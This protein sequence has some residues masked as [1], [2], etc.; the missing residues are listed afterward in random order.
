MCSFRNQQRLLWHLVRMPR[1]Y[2]PQ[3]MQQAQHTK[4][5]L[6]VRARTRWR[7]FTS[8]LALR[9]SLGP[10]QSAGGDPHKNSIWPAALSAIGI[11]A[12][13]HVKQQENYLEEQL[14]NTIHVAPSNPSQRVPRSTYYP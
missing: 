13:D 3:E 10:L 2:S 8:H 11:M 5:G 4:E 7:G 6:Q 9:V 12:C 14:Q 1:R